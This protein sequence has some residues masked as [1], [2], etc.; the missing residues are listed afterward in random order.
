MNMRQRIG[1]KPMQ[2]LWQKWQAI[3]PIQKGAFRLIGRFFVLFI[4]MNILLTPLF[5]HFA[6]DYNIRL[7]HDDALVAHRFISSGEMVSAEQK[8]A[9]VTH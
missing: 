8:Q 2:V 3:S 5:M 4:I 6:R 7:I 1:I 9:F